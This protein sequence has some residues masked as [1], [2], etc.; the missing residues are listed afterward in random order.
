MHGNSL[1]ATGTSTPAG[2][3]ESPPFMSHTDYCKPEAR[4]MRLNTCMFAAPLCPIVSGRAGA[5]RP[6]VMLKLPKTMNGTKAAPVVWPRYTNH[7]AATAP[8]APAYES[9]PVISLGGAHL[10]KLTIGAAVQ[11]ARIH[12]AC[13]DK[14]L[15]TF[16]EG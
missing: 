1:F 15:Q 9:N 12:T 5:A 14:H 16:L 10:A 8:S 3:Q 13:L 11:N 7:G 6:A 2:N 4:E